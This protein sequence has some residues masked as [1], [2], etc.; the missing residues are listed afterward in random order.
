MKARI[1]VA[2]QCTS[3]GVRFHS[4]P[5]MLLSI[6]EP[7]VIPMQIKSRS[8]EQAQGSFEPHFSTCRLH[9]RVASLRSSALAS[10]LSSIIFTMRG[11]WES[12]CLRRDS[13]VPAF[14]HIFTLECQIQII[15]HLT[16]GPIGFNTR[17]SVSKSALTSSV[18][19]I[20]P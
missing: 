13:P 10:A 2:N 9:A 14:T 15:L 5:P 16:S 19:G 1:L 11:L 4:K 6:R 7:R 12:R 8:S 3:R 18:M 20:F 17:L